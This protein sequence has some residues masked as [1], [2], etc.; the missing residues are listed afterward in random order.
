L[1]PAAMAGAL[2]AATSRIKPQTIEILLSIFI[3]PS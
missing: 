3:V 2:M 1:P